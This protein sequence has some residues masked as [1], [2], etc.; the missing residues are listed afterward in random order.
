MRSKKCRIGRSDYPDLR[1]EGFKFDCRKFPRL[2]GFS[3]LKHLCAHAQNGDGK[4]REETCIHIEQKFEIMLHV[5]T[6]PRGRPNEC[7]YM[8]NV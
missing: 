4:H 7:V 1:S 3:H 8:G 2:M 5:P 6:K